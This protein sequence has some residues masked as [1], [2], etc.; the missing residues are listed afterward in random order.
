MEAYA[1]IRLQNI[2][3]NYQ[4]L[5]Q[6]TGKNVIAVIKDNAYGHGLVKVAQT[7][8]KSNVFMLCVSTISEAVQ[9][10][11]SMIF[12]PV[13][14]LGR[15]DDAKL[16]FSFKITPGVSTLSQLKN[17]AKDNIP[18]PIHLEIETGMHR[19]GLLPEELPEAKEILLRSKLVL[20]GIYTH[21]CSDDPS[22]QEER[23][24]AALSQFSDFRKLTVHCQASSYIRTPCS[25]ANALRIGIALY[26]YSP[27]IVLSPCMKLFLP[28]IRCHRIDAETPVGY[29][30]A[31]KAETQGYIL[32]VPIG[33]ALGFSRLRSLTLYYQEQYLRQIGLSCMDLTMFFSPI[34]VEEGTYINFFDRK[35]IESLLQET[36]DSIYYLLSGLSPMIKRVY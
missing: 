8:S 29:H 35:N 24:Q 9:L 18:L 14:L 27:D 6:F 20:K 16:L 28:V 25:F 10:R 12:S 36:D 21:F 4:K 13:L 34:P 2:A 3:E 11:K 1:E 7:L 17:L 23:F 19:L 32:T 30:L 22:A 31:Q 15:C 5:R 26:G 33:Y